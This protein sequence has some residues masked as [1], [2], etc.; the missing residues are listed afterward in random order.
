MHAI[1]YRETLNKLKEL[2]YNK[3]K[4]YTTNK[5]HKKKPTPLE[6]FFFVVWPRFCHYVNNKFCTTP[7]I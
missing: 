5:S 4:T 6:F 1:A 2:I 3:I 7:T